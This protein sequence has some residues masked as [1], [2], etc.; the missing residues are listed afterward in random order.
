[1]LTPLLHPITDT[2]WAIDDAATSTRVGYI[3]RENGDYYLTDTTDRDVGSFCTPEQ[4]AYALPSSLTPTV[5][6]E[7]RS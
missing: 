4:A 5:V 2:E 7:L 3:V 6:T 1:M